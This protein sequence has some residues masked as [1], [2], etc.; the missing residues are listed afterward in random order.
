YVSRSI[1][2]AAWGQPQTNPPSRFLEEIG[3]DL[4]HWE[5]TDAAYTSWSGTGGL[6]SSGSGSGLAE[7]L[8]LD[9]T[10][11]R[12]ASALSKSVPSLQPGDRV[13]HDR[14]GLGRVLAVQGQGNRAQAQIDFGDQV[15]WLVLRH[16][17]IQKL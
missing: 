5:R 2:R 15:M 16:A 3:D 8:G 13:N 10:L 1:T 11:V 14:W 17:P 4:V 6:G 9:P 7:R 12:P